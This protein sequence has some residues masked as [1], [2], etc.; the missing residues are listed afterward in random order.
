MTG[1]F[2]GLAPFEGQDNRAN[3]GRPHQEFENPY[4][5]QSPTSETYGEE[6]RKK[7]IER[8]RKVFI[9]GIESRCCHVLL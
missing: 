5:A 1:L 2:D 6:E 8:L 9:E 3:T 4:M 7:E